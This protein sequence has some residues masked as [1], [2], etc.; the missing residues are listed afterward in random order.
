MVEPVA[1]WSEHL[2][3]IVVP[4]VGSHKKDLKMPDNASARSI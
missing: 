3:F 2:I 4:S 1:A